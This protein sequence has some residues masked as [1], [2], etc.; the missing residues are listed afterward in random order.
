MFRAWIE[1]LENKS[2]EY[3]D[4]GY[5]VDC[6]MSEAWNYCYGGII[7]DFNIWD[8]SVATLRD[9]FWED[10]FVGL[11]AYEEAIIN[12]VGRF[13]CKECGWFAWDHISQIGKCSNFNI[14]R[15]TNS[16]CISLKEQSVC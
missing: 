5:T 11:E 12:N 14:E 6:A 9:S 1:V 4:D 10:S 3:M 7:E 15:E 13:P 16:R 8:L 2:K